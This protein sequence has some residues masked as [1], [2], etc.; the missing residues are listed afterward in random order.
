MQGH[1]AE[2]SGD[3][4]A[5][6]TKHAL[7]RMSDRH[8]RS[9]DIDNVLTYGRAIQI[10]GAIIYVVGIKEIKFQRDLG[11]NLERCEG[12]HV[13]CSQSGTV[14]TAYRN[15]NFRGLKPRYGKVWRKSNKSDDY[16]HG[17]AAA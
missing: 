14:L 6:L 11:I 15:H 12:I 5:I 1:N 13:V 4:E 2:W 8:I 10:R 17:H 3:V 7:E 16:F 9:S